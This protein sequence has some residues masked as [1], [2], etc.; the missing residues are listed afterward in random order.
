MSK[1][2]KLKFCIKNKAIFGLIRKNASEILTSTN[3]IPK[4]EKLKRRKEGSFNTGRWTQE[5]H[6]KFI[7]ALLKYGN[8]W[9]NVQNHVGSRSSSQARS[10]AQK[11]FV[12]IGKTE[13]ENLKLDFENNS[14]RSLNQLTNCLSHDRMV[15][16]L[17]RLNKL[18][19]EFKNFSDTT[20]YKIKKINH[21]KEF[22]K[23]DS[24][25]LY[26]SKN[27][28]FEDSINSIENHE[29]I[30]LNNE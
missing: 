22:L 15:K 27:T 2:K 9:K 7:D 24:N 21:K 20:D 18:A 28:M 29:E 10:H 6:K 30:M 5:E 8:E 17:S 1:T 23:S 25:S 26:Y 11:F 16:E 12:K 13:I 19:L 14:L 4:K 3:S